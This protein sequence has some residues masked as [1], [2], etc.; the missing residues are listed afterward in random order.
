M[1]TKRPPRPRPSR[2]KAKTQP[3]KQKQFYDISTNQVI[4]P[5]EDGFVNEIF[6]PEGVEANFKF[7]LHDGNFAGAVKLQAEG[8]TEL[9]IKKLCDLYLIDESFRE[10]VNSIINGALARQSESIKKQ[11]SSLIIKK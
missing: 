3:Q 6:I 7:S 8:D 10:F 5:P 11:L 2:A 4:P 1:T 9:G